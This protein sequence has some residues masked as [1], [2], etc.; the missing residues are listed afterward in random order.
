MHLV[1]GSL[2]KCIIRWMSALRWREEGRRVIGVR[3]GG[4]SS[5]CYDHDFVG[6]YTA[7]N[8]SDR[9]PCCCARRG[10]HC[11]NEMRASSTTQPDDRCACCILL[12]PSI[13]PRSISRL[14]DQGKE[15]KSLISLISGEA[16]ERNLLLAQMPT[17]RFSV[18]QCKNTNR[19][20]INGIFR[21]QNRPWINGWREYDARCALLLSCSVISHN[22]LVV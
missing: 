5:M 16:C 19:P 8:L 10:Y 15:I 13:Y 18:F 17:W 9:D 1:V 14:K 11:Q 7:I 6:E 20:C 3:Q 22:K 12:P 2:M 4:E 21:F